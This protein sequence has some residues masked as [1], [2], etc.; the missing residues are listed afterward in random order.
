MQDFISNYCVCQV[1]AGDR[2]KHVLNTHVRDILENKLQPVFKRQTQIHPV[3][4]HRPEPR[5][6]AAHEYDLHE[7][8]EWKTGNTLEILLWIVEKISAS[9]FICNFYSKQ[10]ED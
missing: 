9:P 8:Q 10:H 4:S 3:L 2:E 6:R 7:N 1:P 5:Y